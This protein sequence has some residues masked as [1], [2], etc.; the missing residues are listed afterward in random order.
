MSSLD[1]LPNYAPQTKRFPWGCL[2]GGCAT[3]LLLMIGLAVGTGVAVFYTYKGQISKYTSESPK[4]LPAIEYSEDEIKEVAARVESIKSSLDKGE[5]PKV[6]E[7]TADDL[8]ALINQNEDLRGKLF[9][10][11]D[12]GEVTADVSFPADLIPM[13][14]GRYFNGSVSTNVSLE[15]GVLIVTLA[16]AEVNGQKIP[17]E[18]MDALKNENL[19]KELYKNPKIEKILGKFERL[20]IEKDKII[21]TPKLEVEPLN[22]PEPTP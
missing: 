17:K 5:V 4:E 1:D 14:K 8:N 22:T 2:I 19:A 7:L 3:V 18:I 16:D 13:A 20:L 12:D 10:R 6:V 9:V 15:N 21:L 11:I